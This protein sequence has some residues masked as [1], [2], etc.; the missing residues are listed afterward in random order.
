[1][2]EAIDPAD[3]QRISSKGVDGRRS[4]RLIHL[5][6]GISVEGSV[7]KNESSLKLHDRLMK[8]LS[9]KAPGK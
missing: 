1:M 6:T 9:E 2:A 4:I 3:I 7:A 8:E 5:P